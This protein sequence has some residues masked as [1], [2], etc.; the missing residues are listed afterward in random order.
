M[1]QTRGKYEDPAPG[2]GSGAQRVPGAMAGMVGCL[3][4]MEV[5]KVVAEFGEYLPVSHLDLG[6]SYLWIWGR[7][8]PL[9]A[10][11]LRPGPPGTRQVRLTSCG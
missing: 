10:D 11:A 2:K 3:A 9:A 1:W 4:T 7:G 8:V 5:L 6:A